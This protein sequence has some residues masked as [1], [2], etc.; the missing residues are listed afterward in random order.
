VL[1]LSPKA[2]KRIGAKKK[3]GVAP[4]AVKPVAPPPNAKPR[5]AEADRPG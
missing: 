4:V 2:A 5:E 3:Q 1:D